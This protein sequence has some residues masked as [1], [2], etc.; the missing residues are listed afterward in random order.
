M[1]HIF[2]V[3]AEIIPKD[4]YLDTLELAL[5]SAPKKVVVMVTGPFTSLYKAL[6]ARPRLANYIEGIWFS[7]AGLYS[8]G[9]VI[10]HE[11][12]HVRV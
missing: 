10:G 5:K 4:S 7:G 1:P 6:E 9:N 8:P 11:E 2:I 3:S 12:Y